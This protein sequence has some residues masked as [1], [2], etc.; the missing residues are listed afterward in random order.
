M[1]DFPTGLL[2]DP[3]LRAE[4]DLLGDLMV[5]TVGVSGRLTIAEIDGALGLD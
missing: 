5:A 1:S 4:I 2:A 3:V